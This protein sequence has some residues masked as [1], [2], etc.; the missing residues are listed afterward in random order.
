VTVT[1]GGSPVGDP[2]TW[3]APENCAPV[4]V[5]GKAD[6]T[7]LSVILTNPEG[8]AT[9]YTVVVGGEEKTGQ[10]AVGETREVGPFAAGAGAKAT[11]TVGSGAPTTV[12]WI[13][14]E[15]CESPSP[16]PSS[17]P[18]PDTGQSLT[19]LVSAGAALVLG[20]AGLL[21]LLYLRRRRAGAE[22]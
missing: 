1:S 21:A 22:S 8:P 9:T 18:L 16:T 11:V 4:Q 7:T 6:C 10:L 14:P 3:T 17:T 2:F 13:K 20:G 5:S 19:G 12:D 15:N